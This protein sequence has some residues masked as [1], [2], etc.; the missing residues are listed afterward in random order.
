[1]MK[2]EGS[3]QI[4]WG[5]VTSRSL[6]SNVFDNIVKVHGVKGNVHVVV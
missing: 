2:I 5:M 6:R 1:M 4:H 3:N